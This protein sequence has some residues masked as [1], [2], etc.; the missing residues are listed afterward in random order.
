MANFLPSKGNG[1]NYM[2]NNFNRLNNKSKAI[3]HKNNYKS[4]KKR[5]L[6]ENGYFIIFNGFVESHLLTKIS[7]NA[8]KLYIYLGI[9]S[10]NTTGEVWHS[11][12]T[13]AKYFDRSERTIRGWMLELE[14]LHLIKRMR[15]VYDGEVHTY[16]QPYVPGEKREKSK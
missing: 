5:S 12:K 3:S 4:W 10:Q 11:N 15:L 2:N 1:G 14:E 6:D 9:H 13:I 7:G 16:L 8:L